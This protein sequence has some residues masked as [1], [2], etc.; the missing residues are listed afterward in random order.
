MQDGPFTPEIA[1][2][3][4]QSIQSTQP[5]VE[6][7]QP[8]PQP[9]QPKNEAQQP[10]SDVLT[11]KSEPE[12]PKNSEDQENQ[13]DQEA[14]KFNEII[15]KPKSQEQKAAE[16]LFEI[17]RLK[18][19]NQRIPIKDKDGRENSA[20]YFDPLQDFALAILKLYQDNAPNQ[21]FV[22]ANKKGE[23]TSPLNINGTKVSKITKYNPD[24]QSFVC[25]DDSGK[26][27]DVPRSQIIETLY[28]IFENSSEAKKYK[29]KTRQLAE[30]L[31]QSIIGQSVDQAPTDQTQSTDQSESDEKTKKPETTITDRDILDVIIENRKSL[32]HENFLLYKEQLNPL[33]EKLKQKIETISDPEKRKAYQERFIQV[34]E[35]DKNN[36]FITRD[37]FREILSLGFELEGE[38]LAGQLETLTSQ[39]KN[40]PD[41]ENLKQLIEKL[42]KDLKDYTPEGINSELNR[43]LKILFKELNTNPEFITEMLG[44]LNEDD[45]NGLFNKLNQFD[46][47]Y[48][49]SI[50]QLRKTGKV[51]GIGLLV[52]MLIMLWKSKDEMKDG[53]QIAAAMPG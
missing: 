10:Q 17:G 8:Q 1:A 12:S 38:K 4:P 32:A 16:T 7:P 20:D 2:A 11:D 52:A 28:Q 44:F 34:L 23:T 22:F 24:S 25:Y 51:I 39:L 9:D 36:T 46:A 6:A 26:Q 37:Q 53:G 41:N 40:D 14:K 48:Q 30:K 3:Q 33:F 42:K 50:E 45:F 5:T 15:S 47:K 21:V 49:Q 35:N 27:I 19:E 31:Y 13:E 18:T 29:D 43:G